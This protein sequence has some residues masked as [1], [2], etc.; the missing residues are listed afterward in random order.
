MISKLQFKIEN[1][2]GVLADTSFK[3]DVCSYWPGI[4]HWVQIRTTEGGFS[5]LGVNSSLTGL[6]IH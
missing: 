6:T 4:Q 3:K 1:R 2:G 5:P